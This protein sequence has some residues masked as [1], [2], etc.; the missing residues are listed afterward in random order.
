MALPSDHKL[1]RDLV[2]AGVVAIAADVKAAGANQ[3]F[4]AA[5][6]AVAEEEDVEADLVEDASGETWKTYVK[7]L[8]GRGYF[9][10]S[11]INQNYVAALLRPSKAGQRGVAE[12]ETKLREMARN[13]LN[14]VW[15]MCKRRRGVVS[16]PAKPKVAKTSAT[17]APLADK[18]AQVSAQPSAQGTRRGSLSAGG[19]GGK[20]V[21]EEECA[22]AAVGGGGSAAAVAAPVRPVAPEEECVE[23]RFT[24]SKSQFVAIARGEGS[25][26]PEK[27]WDAF[28]AEDLN[29]HRV[30]K[31]MVQDIMRGRFGPPPGKKPCDH[32]G[33]M[34][35][36]NDGDC[37]NGCETCRGK[38]HRLGHCCH[39]CRTEK[40][41][42][43]LSKASFRARAIIAMS[44]SG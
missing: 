24:V 21:C 26:N 31:H 36:E 11:A 38:A 13:W 22:A 18:S 39:D 16:P 17:K 2:S 9:E 27:A 7:E 12:D 5:V 10:G 14:T 23:V 1:V 41:K 33:A 32:C 19:G 43:D 30:V 8:F 44:D 4:E 29:E 20:D 42:E 35:E 3:R 34:W 37:R 25:T 6:W 15:A 28:V 40:F